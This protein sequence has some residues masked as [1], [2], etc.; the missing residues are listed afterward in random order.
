[1]TQTN[2]ALAAAARAHLMDVGPKPPVVMVRG[3]GVELFDV[4]GRRYLDFV[5]G[6]AVDC[7]GHAPSAVAE[8]LAAQARTL[9]NASPGYWNAPQIAFARRLTAAS[10]L[11]RAW[12]GSTGAEVNEGAVKLARRWG[13]LRRGGAHEVITALDGFHGRTLAMMA[14]TGK[15]HWRTLFPP[16][17]PGFT[18]VPFNDLGAVEAAVTDRTVAVMVEPV[19]GEGGVVPAAPGYLRGLRALCDRRGLLLVLDEV[20]TGYGR[21]GAMFAFQREGIRP[22]V[23]TL[24][25]GIGAGFPLAALLAREDVC[26]FEPGDQGGTY[27]GQPLAMAVGLAVLDEVERRGLAARAAEVGAYLG[28]RLAELAVDGLV[29]GI[30]GAGLL[31]GFDA[32]RRTGGE[33]V[34]SALDRGLLVNSPRPRTVRLMPPLIV[35]REHVDEAVAILREVL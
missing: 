11:E 4:E 3:E 8:A 14:A 7:L 32:V 25:K 23:L 5:A 12:F 9:L 30:R 26:V 19:Q 16:A 21:T 33:V 28:E 13:R 1:M 18:H 6:W 27:S 29:T 34:A 24:G 35:G 22:D 31:V 10:G 2:A 15:P 20:Q 17:V